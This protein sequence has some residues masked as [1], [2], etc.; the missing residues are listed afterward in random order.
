MRKEESRT[1]KAMS[2]EHRKRAT[3]HGYSDLKQRVREL[4]ERIEKLEQALLQNGIHRV[5]GRGAM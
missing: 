2:D 5:I 1:N 4:E 3:I